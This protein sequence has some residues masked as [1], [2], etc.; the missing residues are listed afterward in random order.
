MGGWASK[1]QRDRVAAALLAG[2]GRL[3]PKKCEGCGK[4]F[5]PRVRHP[6]QAVCRRGCRL[7]L[8]P[9]HLS[10]RKKFQAVMVPCPHPDCLRWDGTKVIG[11]PGPAALLDEHLL[12]DHK[13]DPDTYLGRQG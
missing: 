12:W 7:I 2:G 6:H 4:L 5:V 10:D 11:R 9:E 8:G 3:P 1:I 13:V